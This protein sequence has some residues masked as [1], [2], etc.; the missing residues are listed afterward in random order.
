MTTKVCTGDELPCTLMGK[1]SCTDSQ[2]S[3]MPNVGEHR[4]LRKMPWLVQR[5]QLNAE[6]GV[7][8]R[9]A[10][11]EPFYIIARLRVCDSGK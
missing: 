11:T 10:A 3:L 4:L 5:S 9:L 7:H 1:N 2:T 8:I 6:K